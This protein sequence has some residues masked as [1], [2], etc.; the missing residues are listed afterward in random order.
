MTAA[1]VLDTSPLGD[2]CHPQNPARAAAVRQWVAD[3]LAARRR[4]IIPEIADYEVRRERLRNNSR[5][6]IMRLDNYEALLEYLPLSTA[7]MHHA[8]ELWAVARRSGRPT[9]SDPA[10]DGDV[11][12]AAQALS[13]SGPVIVATAN[14]RHLVQ[15]VPCDLWQNITPLETVAE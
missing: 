9:A 7:I 14:V 11:I 1:V 13:L 12:I 4:V 5:R 2:L 15:F 10:L 3:L 8:A 6:A